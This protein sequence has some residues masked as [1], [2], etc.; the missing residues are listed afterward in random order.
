MFFFLYKTTN[1]IN[2]KIYIGVHKTENMDDGYLG[3]GII[4]NKAIRKHGKEN[5]IREEIEFFD[6]FD[7]AFEM[8]RK[9]VTEEFI[10]RT[11]N[12]NVKV[13]GQGG[14]DEA[15]QERG[16]EKYRERLRNDPEFREYI[17]K[18]RKG[19]MEA[20]GA[21]AQQLSGWTKQR[22]I[23]NADNPDFWKWHKSIV[24]KGKA[25]TQQIMNE[26]F[27]QGWCYLTNPKSGKR[28]LIS[29]DDFE[30]YT[31]DGWYNK[32]RNIGNVPKRHKTTKSK[33]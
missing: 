28:K 6:N 24:Q 10:S 14:F 18:V 3:S 29:P 17:S 20:R 16:R 2:G 4:L 25:A 26:K 22:Y 30:K 12:Y 8:E 15:M 7:E 32:S 33:T 13:G 27:K 31:I 1:V 11:D 19:G 9:I 5:F 23:D 21:T